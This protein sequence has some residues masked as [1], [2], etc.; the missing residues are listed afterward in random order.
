MKS[1]IEVIDGAIALVEK[2]GGW[3]QGTF[4]RDKNGEA[5]GLYGNTIQDAV[6]F[7]LEGAIRYSAGLH[8]GLGSWLQAH[9][10]EVLARQEAFGHDDNGLRLLSRYNDDDHTTQEDAILVLKRVR[11]RLEEQMQG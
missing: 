6:S 10:L 5:I 9:P 7:C 11:S 1:D 8:L 4:C 3:C 2:D